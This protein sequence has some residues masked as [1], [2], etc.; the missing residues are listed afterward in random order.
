MHLVLMVDHL[1]RRVQDALRSSAVG[2][3]N[4]GA[5][6]AQAGLS[7]SARAVCSLLNSAAYDMLTAA[8][9]HHE[10]TESGNYLVLYLDHPLVRLVAL[11][12]KAY[13][14]EGGD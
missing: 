11:L 4:L 5:P 14:G 1:R 12:H 3:I 13:A 6:A 2:G 8:E 10:G 9:T 7:L